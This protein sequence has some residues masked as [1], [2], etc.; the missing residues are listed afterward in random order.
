MNIDKIIF[1]DVN[2]SPDEFNINQ[3]IG[4]NVSFLNPY[5][6]YLMKTKYIDILSGIDCWF[7]DGELGRKLT[8][9]LYARKI[10]RYSFDFTSIAHD[11]FEY[12]CQNNKKVFVIGSTQVNID[13]FTKKIQASYPNISICA[14]SGY[15]SSIKERESTISDIFNY[16][17]DIVVVGMGAGLQEMFLIDLRKTGWSGIGFTCG[18]FIHQTASS[19]DIKYYPDFIDRFNLRWVYRMYDEPILIKR[20]F[21]FYPLSIFLML[22]NRL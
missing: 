21:L 22:K 19:T 2:L 7:I 6:Y 5:S 9:L 18:G 13:K 10:K 15:F 12:A 17:P 4:K 20:Y 1:K 11:V 3:L 16:Q 8:N 14:K